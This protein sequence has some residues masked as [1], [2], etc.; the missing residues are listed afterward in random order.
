MKSFV[1]KNSIWILIIIISLIFNIFSIFTMI[2]NNN[3][4]EEKIRTS[5]YYIKQH[6]NHLSAALDT[7]NVKN[8]RNYD[9]KYNLARIISWLEQSLMYYKVSEKPISWENSNNLTSANY[10]YRLDML[11]LYEDSLVSNKFTTDLSSKDIDLI[12]SDFVIIKDWLEE[13]INNLGVTYYNDTVFENEILLKLQW[14]RNI[15]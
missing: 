11:E 2:E 4:K 5:N 7:L 8:T 15:S 13:R 10:T 3:L 6:Y 12:I 9:Y 1:K 14:N